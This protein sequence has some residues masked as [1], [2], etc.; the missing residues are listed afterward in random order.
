VI[1]VMSNPTRKK[2]KKGDKKFGRNAKKPSHQRYNIERRWE[3]NKA[4]KAA[5]IKKMLAKK[6]ARKARKNG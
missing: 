1:F 4:R 2:G 6:A 3:K 5:K